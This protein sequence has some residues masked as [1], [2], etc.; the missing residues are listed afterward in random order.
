VSEHRSGAP[1]ARQNAADERRSRQH[2]EP[3]LLGID[4]GS[5]RIKAVLVDGAGRESASAAVDTPFAERADGVEAGADDVLDAVRW[6]VA[7]LGDDRRRVVGVGVAGMAESGAPLDSRGRFLAP[8][9]PWHDG[10]GEDVADRLAERF[11]PGLALALGQ[12]MRAVATVAKLGWLLDHG[13]EGVSRWL[14]VPELVLHALTG[15]EA[16]EWSLAARTGCF[17]VGGRAWMPEV[18]E[19]AGFDVAVFPEVGSAGDD[20][21]R[22]SPAGAEWAGLPGGIPVT[23]AGHDHLAGVVGSGADPGDLVNSVGTAETVVGRSAERP[24]V[25]AALDRGVAVT[26]FPGAD[27]WAAL[28]S[29]ARAGLAIAAAADALGL[30]PAELDELAADAPKGVLDAPDLLD[31]L[32]RRDPPAL[33]DG[34]PGAVWWT[35]LDALAVCT[36]EAVEKVTGL[37]G[38]A[39]RMVVFGGGA[40]SDSWMRAKADRVPVP[41]WRSTAGEPAA[42]GAAVYAGVAAGWWRS[43][44]A[45]PRPPLQRLE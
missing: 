29:G 35:L 2:L 39:A 22:V 44:G 12:K 26:V 34:P 7:E 37:L 4:V 25:G 20:M 38:D 15:V 16:T 27:G 3:L 42:R 6:A 19:V 43:P 32:H 5:S 17:D 24:D 9:I 40:G 23:V 21:G 8:V 36:A 30:D 18:A 33:P 1:P 11:G 41:V 10:R 31:S 13:V 14:G 28:A 45:A